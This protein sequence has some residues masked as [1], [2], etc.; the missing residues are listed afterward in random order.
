MYLFIDNYQNSFFVLSRS[1]EIFVKF[2]KKISAVGLFPVD[3][4]QDF[5]AINSKCIAPS[6]LSSGKISCVRR[7][8]IENLFHQNKKYI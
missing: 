7:K 5:E 4:L 6:N 1:E 2:S 3:I 8:E